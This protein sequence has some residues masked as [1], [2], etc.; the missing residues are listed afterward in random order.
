MAIIVI[1]GRNR[2]GEIE[3]AEKE[4]WR[5]LLLLASLLLDKNIKNTYSAFGQC[6]LLIQSNTLFD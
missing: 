2:K 3:I 5:L 6:H 1:I 4:E